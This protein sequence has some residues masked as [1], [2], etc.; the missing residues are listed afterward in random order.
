VSGAVISNCGRY[1]YTLKRE[2]MTGIG[3]CL[4][5]MLN[6]STADASE[7]D[8]TIR[9]CIGFAQCWGYQQLAVGHLFA[10]RATDPLG[11]LDVTLDEA[12]GSE[13]DDYLRDLSH[14]A[15]LIVAAWGAHR[16]TAYRR[17][18]VTE[19]F[20]ES[21]ADLVCLGTTKSGAPRHPLYVKGDTEPQPY[22]LHSEAVA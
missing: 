13:N 2:W 9:R 14:G 15:S 16:L 11:L 18:E 17:A 5:V 12:V 3:T 8:P 19:M 22:R 1:R 21:E 6:P 20:T 10:Y 4:F 7:D